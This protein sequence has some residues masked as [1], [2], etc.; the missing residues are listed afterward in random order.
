MKLVD[1]WKEAWRWWTVWGGIV[2]AVLSA[3]QLALPEL[4]D[5]LPPGVFAYA[6]LALGVAIPF[7]RVISQV[8]VPQ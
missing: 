1:N 8:K 4:H 7:L 5:K 2:I 3:V 6:T